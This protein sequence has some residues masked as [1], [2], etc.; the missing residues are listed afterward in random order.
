MVNSPNLQ[1]VNNSLDPTSPD[2]YKQPRR[3]M[4]EILADLSKPIPNKYLEKRKQGGVN[5]NYLPW[6][7]AVKLLDRCAG[8]HWDYA[9][10]SIHTTRD[11]IFVTARITIHP[12]FVALA[13]LK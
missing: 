3:P 10:T 1:L 7:N 2:W 6:F 5:L 12:S 13:R 4:A 9:I 8:G 11:R